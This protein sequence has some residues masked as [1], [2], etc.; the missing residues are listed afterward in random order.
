[1]RYLVLSD[2]HA[3]LEALTE[4]GAP[5]QRET[6]LAGF[7]PLVLMRRLQALGAYGR[8]GLQGG[9]PQYL[10]KIPPALETLRELLAAG[11]FQMG[12]PALE[13]WLGSVLTANP[14]LP[15]QP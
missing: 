13:A 11:H 5:Q 9:K 1:M 4:V 14:T 15:E 12:L 2:I 6:F 3:N 7:Y 10:Q 8:I